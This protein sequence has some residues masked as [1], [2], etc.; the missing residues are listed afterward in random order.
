MSKMKKLK[1]SIQEKEFKTLIN[2]T[3]N[4]PTMREN[5]KQNLTRLFTLL[6]YTGMR[7]NEVLTLTIKNIQEGIGN[8]E[9]IVKAHSKTSKEVYFANSCSDERAK[10]AI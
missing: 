2:F 5:T 4:N 10:E 6:Y 7:I 1:K 3:Q 9:L 8:G